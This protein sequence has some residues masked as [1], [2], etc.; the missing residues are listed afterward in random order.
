MNNSNIRDI[1]IIIFGVNGLNISPLTRG[2]MQGDGVGFLFALNMFK[3]QKR[4]LT[5]YIKQ[6]SL[7]KKSAT[8]PLQE[9]KTDPRMLEERLFKKLAAMLPTESH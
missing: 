8:S 6:P 1:C 2:N 7:L 4:E 5:L 9:N 3:N